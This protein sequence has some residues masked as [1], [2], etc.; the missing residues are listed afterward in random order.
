VDSFL[1]IGDGVTHSLKTIILAGGL[2]T[3]LSEETTLRPKP[4]VEIGGY[5][6]LWHIMNI[7][8]FHGQKEFIL[9]LGYKGEVVKDYFLRFGA[10]TSDLSVD[11]A[12]G[13]TTVHDGRRPDW[14]VHLVDTGDSTQTGGR[15]RRLKEWVGDDNTFMMTYG[16]GVADVDLAALL[17]F[18]RSHGKLA[19][20][21]AVRPPA[22][23]GGLALEGDRVARFAEKPQT[24]EG[25]INGGFFVLDRRVFD[26]IDGD[27]V[28]FEGAP[29][30][31]L[32][33]EGQL[34]AFRH[35]GFWPRETTPGRTLECGASPLEGVVMTG[36]GS[37][38]ALVTG[39]TGL[40]GSWLIKRLLGEG[41]KVVALVRD[42]DPQT[43]LI[44][45]GD[46]SR[47]TVVSG[48]LEEYADLERAISE[49][50]VDTVFHL[51]AQAI[52]GTAHRS[53]LMTFESNIRGSY[54]LLEACRVHA[55]LVKRLVVASSDKAYGTAE[56]LPYTEDMAANG[57]HP[58][59]VSKS[60]TDLLAQTYAATYGLPVAVARCGNIFGGGDLNWSR[61]VPGTI[62]CVLENRA[63]VLRSDGTFTRDYLYVEDVVDAYLALA[64]S[65]D[66]EGVRG[67]A[68]NFS[69]E[70]QVSVLELTRLV[71]ELMGRPDLEPVIQNTAQGEIRDQYLDASKAQRVLGWSCHFGL[72]EGLERSIAW[73][74]AYLGKGV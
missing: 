36:W 55:S 43:E 69:P 50:E 44:R 65:A 13:A 11:L 37:R 70:R 10:L 5:P 45:S 34:M 1:I 52:V 61:I 28:S 30:E 27:E 73:Y 17:A 12:T 22:R 23:F 62:R 46:I 21:T 74:Q 16:D 59:D 47:C 15:V 57:R 63:P 25:W 72:K 18:H 38:T 54:N 64:D 68:F 67:E 33:Q 53:P 41:A 39:S 24:G 3:R 58:Y 19:T 20:V 56:V 7:Y 9:A 14:R 49:H 42:W 4:M 35:Q 51:G 32:T 6:I 31:R 71:L 2:G 29:L 40:V 48:R 60:C 26:Y 66:R 8:A